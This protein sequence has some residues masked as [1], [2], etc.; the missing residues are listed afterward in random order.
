MQRSKCEQN[1][2]LDCSCSLCKSTNN[3]SYCLLGLDSSYV[4][5][6]SFEVKPYECL[7]VKIGFLRLVADALLQE[8]R[9]KNGASQWPVIGSLLYLL[10]V[11]DVISVNTLLFTDD[12]KMAPPRS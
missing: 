2:Q 7:G 3:I 1:N 6:R 12:F 9:I 8:K 11:N 10:L 4:P 5:L